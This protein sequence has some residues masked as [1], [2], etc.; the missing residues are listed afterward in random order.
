MRRTDDTASCPPAAAPRSHPWDLYDW[1]RDVPEWRPT[2]HKRSAGAG[3]P[4]RGDLR[5][6]RRG[7]VV[8]LL[9]ACALL[10]VALG[11]GA[12][13]AGGGTAAAP[14]ADP[15]SRTVV[16][17]D[18][19]TLWW[20]AAEAAPGADPAPVIRCIMALNG[21]STSFLR[22]GQQLEVPVGGPAADCPR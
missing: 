9:M 2:G 20:I 19:D 14:S 3:A 11:A 8:L 13:S 1:A 7:R 17:G 21:L 4:R 16:V 18:G 22:A 6:T 15:P 5:L 10:V 12:A